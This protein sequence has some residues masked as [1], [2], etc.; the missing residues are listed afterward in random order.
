MPR[1]VARRVYKASVTV[2]CLW[3]LSVHE[4]I[5]RNFIGLIIMNR[6]QHQK[7]NNSFVITVCLWELLMWLFLELELQLG[8]RSHEI[9]PKW[10]K[11]KW[12]LIEMFCRGV[13]CKELKQSCFSLR[14]SLNNFICVNSVYVITAG[15]MGFLPLCTY[16]ASRVP[17]SH[18]FAQSIRRIKSSWLLS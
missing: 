18:I 16:A 7:S 11:Y 6:S 8:S 2:C 1:A 9:L 15:L 5:R 13:I 4:K 12:L 10:W 3:G 17:L 14:N